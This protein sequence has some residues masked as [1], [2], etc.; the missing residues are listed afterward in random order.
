MDEV[1]KLRLAQNE[2]IFR[3]INEQVLGLEEKFGSRDGGFTCECAD[4]SCTAN[5]FL[6]LDEYE[7]IHADEQRFFVVPG[8]ER[9]E[10]ETV[11]ERHAAYF[12]VEKAV[13]VPA[14]HRG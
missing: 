13:R 2:A 3:A 4:A 5:V 6:P 14:L 10:I 7:R 12:V 9:P 11:L 1:T 8:H